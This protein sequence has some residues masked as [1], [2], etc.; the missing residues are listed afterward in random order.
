MAVDNNKW[1]I[2]HKLQIE[3]RGHPN[4]NNNSIIAALTSDSPLLTHGQVGGYC[5]P[6]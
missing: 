3:F 6:H 4:I 1:N 5:R 2:V